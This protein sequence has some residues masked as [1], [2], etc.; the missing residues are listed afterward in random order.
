MVHDLAAD[1]RTVIRLTE[2]AVVVD[3]RIDGRFVVGPAG[4][5]ELLPR[6]AEAAR[7]GRG[8]VLQLERAWLVYEAGPPRLSVDAFDGTT[9]ARVEV[10]DAAAWAAGLEAAARGA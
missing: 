3:D 8:L 6:L 9:I 5:H 1:G 10:G 2:G 4:P 7:T